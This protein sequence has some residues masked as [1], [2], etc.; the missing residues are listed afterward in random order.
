MIPLNTIFEQI[1]SGKNGV[2][3]KSNR[4]SSVILAVI[5][6][7]C[8]TRWCVFAFAGTSVAPY[9]AVVQNA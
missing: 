6:Y 1:E 8:L 2:S 7:S 5:C 3:V 4:L 9:A